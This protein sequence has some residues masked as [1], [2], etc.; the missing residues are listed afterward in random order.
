M[1]PAAVNPHRKNDHVFSLGDRAKKRRLP[2]G[3]AYEAVPLDP[4]VFD[5]DGEIMYESDGKKRK[6]FA[7]NGGRRDFP[8]SGVSKMEADCTGPNDTGRKRKALTEIIH[9][10]GLG[11]DPEAVRSVLSRS[12]RTSLRRQIST[13]LH[14]SLALG[15][16]VDAREIRLRQE[17][18]VILSDSLGDRRVRR[19]ENGGATEL[20]SAGQPV[21][22]GF[23]ETAQSGGPAA[24]G[25]TP[26]PHHRKRAAAGG[27]RAAGGKEKRTPKANTTY[28]HPDFLSA[29]D[30]LPPPEKP[31]SKTPSQKKGAGKGVEQKDPRRQKVEAA[32]GKRMADVFRMCA[33]LLKRIMAHKFSWVFNVPVDAEKLGLHDY[34]TV[35]KKPMD[36]G[37][38]N[39]R[40]KASSYQ[41]PD[42][43]HSDVLLVWS[44]AMTYNGEGND[45]YFM[46]SELKKIFEQGYQKVQ[47]KL[48]EDAAKRREEDELLAAGGGLPEPRDKSEV[49]ELEKRL[50]KL[51]SQLVASTKAQQQ[52]GKAKGGQ[53]KP[54]VADAKKREMTFAEKQKL[55]VNLGKLPPEKLDRIVQIISERN[56]DL[57]QNAD[58]IE[59]D[60]DSLDSET[61]WELERY[62]SN[63]MKSKS[64]RKKIPLYDT[65]Q[66]KGVDAFPASSAG[67]LKEGEDSIDIGDEG[68]LPAQPAA[69]SRAE[70]SRASAGNGA[71]GG[72]AAS[73]SSGSSGSSD[74]SS[75]SDSDS[76]SDSSSSD[77]DEIQSRD[78]GSEASPDKNW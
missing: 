19:S 68:P 16:R 24:L 29:A 23:G 61:L 72:G 76:G 1:T 73:D 43:F 78:A 12:E 28:I 51:E 64:K 70:P 67:D 15:R 2:N 6:N 21:D 77:S 59:L 35:I 63:C 20:S 44:N 62:V 69:P 54:R 3:H 36:L 46:A 42:E 14:S 49:L 8:G 7:P 57:S 18:Q 48:D 33:T 26:Q 10:D 58:E 71:Q 11:N 27:E 34:H 53:A 38:I 75:S 65:V 50:Q 32:R 60:I 9:R 40:M 52:Q 45:V 39:S 4:D 13:D 41:H 55:S 5:I 74:D 22:G 17:P 25:A 30:K 66:P 47:Q 37:T 31:K 56:P